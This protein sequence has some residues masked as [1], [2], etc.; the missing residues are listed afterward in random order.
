MRNQI[1]A[2]A[3]SIALVFLFF[4]IASV[5]DKQ[6]QATLEE[7]SAQLV[8]AQEIEEQ[9]RKMN[10]LNDALDR[11]QVEVAFLKLEL[12]AEQD[13]TKEALLKSEPLPCTSPPTTDAT[14]APM[15]PDTPPPT[16][17]VTTLAPSSSTQPSTALRSVATTP[18]N[19]S[20]LQEKCFELPI[21]SQ[22]PPE[23]WIWPCASGE[24]LEPPLEEELWEA[25]PEDFP[26]AHKPVV[27]LDDEGWGQLGLVPLCSNVHCYTLRGSIFNKKM[28]LKNS[29]KMVSLSRASR[30][31]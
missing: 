11:A 14:I 28:D 27:M 21:V 30:K 31:V 9:S 24:V 19:M 29:T 3:G 5:E 23:P 2:I 13:K 25:V 15:H 8:Q 22:R 16:S 1:F 12:V 7:E 17:Q 6:Q 10:E 18:Q 4:L 20:P 26:V